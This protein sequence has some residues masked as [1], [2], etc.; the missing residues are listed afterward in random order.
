MHPDLSSLEQILMYHEKGIDTTNRRVWERSLP[1]NDTSDEETEKAFTPPY[2][3]AHR[4]QRRAP[5][6]FNREQVP[7]DEATTL[8]SPDINVV[9][10]VEW[11]SS[12]AFDW[13]R[14]M[15]WSPLRF[16]RSMKNS[17]GG[18]SLQ[19]TQYV[20][21]VGTGLGG[22]KGRNGGGRA[23]YAVK[24]QDGVANSSLNQ[25]ILSS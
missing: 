21:S 12:I 3:G 7:P 6:Y 11:D 22:C 24:G 23:S 8:L 1:A 15:M 4:H 19:F 9:V 25:I 20:L 16:R 2:P 10:S 13:R 5:F 14:W 17:G 18:R